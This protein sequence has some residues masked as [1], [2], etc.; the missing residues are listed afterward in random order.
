V[1][2]VHLRQLEGQPLAKLQ[3]P[4]ASHELLVLALNPDE[5]LPDVKRWGSPGTPLMKWLEPVDQCVQFIVADDDQA[6][7]VCEMA[8]RHIVLH[9]QSPDQDFRNY[10]A[11]AIANTAEHARLGGHPD[12]EVG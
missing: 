7:S 2:V 9:G 6:R 10:W 3:F 5:P 11:S 8:V 4:G 12:R 1:Q